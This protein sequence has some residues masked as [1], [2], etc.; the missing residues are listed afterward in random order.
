MV[1]STK[2][3]V[4]AASVRNTRHPES[5]VHT[6]F[7]IRNITPRTFDLPLTWL[8]AHFTQKQYPAE[9]PLMHQDAVGCHVA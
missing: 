1:V 8:A 9:D 7:I 3:L 6:L 5:V 2:S 4:I